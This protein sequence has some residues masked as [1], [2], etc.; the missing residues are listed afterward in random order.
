LL[1]RGGTFTRLRRSNRCDWL[2][3]SFR[4]LRQRLLQ[5]QRQHVV[6]S[7][8]EV[9]LHGIAQVLGNFSD[10]FFIVLGRIASKS[11]ARCAASS[12][13]FNPPIASTLPRSVISPVMPKSRRTRTRLGAL[14]MADSFVMPA[15]GPP[16]GIA[17]SGTWT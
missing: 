6:H 15:E 12:F 5:S 2:R 17:P 10:I 14:A 7:F 1:V 4:N 16:F 13:S 8:N 11:P 3:R 9:Q